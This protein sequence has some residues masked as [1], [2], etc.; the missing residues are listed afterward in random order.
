MKERIVAVSVDK[1][2]TFLT[3]VIHSHVQE[4]QKEE[5]TLRRIM[6]SSYQISNGFYRSIQDAFPEAKDDL[7]M[8]CSGVYIFSCSLSE[9]ELDKR[10]N[11]LFSAYY[12]ESRGQKLIRWVYFSSYGLDNIQAI[13]EAK[14]RLKEPKHWNKIVENNQE[15]LF[16]F[17]QV[18]EVIDNNRNNSRY[19]EEYPLFAKDIN[20]LCKNEDDK[21]RF[22]IAVLKADLDGMGAMFKQIHEYKDYKNISGILNEEISL[23][24]LHRAANCVFPQGSS[25]R[26]FPFYIAGDDI[27]FAVAIED[28]ARGVH[29]CGEIMNTV[30]KKIKES[31]SEEKLAI[32]MGVE[33]TYNKEPIR[34]YMDMVEAQLKNAKSSRTPN[35]L[36]DFSAM[37]ISIGNLTFFAIDY[38][39]IKEKKKDLTCKKRKCKCQKCRERAE[40]NRQLQNVPIWEYFLSDVKLLGYIRCRE[41]GCSGLLGNA[42]FFYTLLEDIT[43]ETTRD[44]PV[45]YINHVLYHLLPKYFEDSNQKLRKL[46]LLLNSRIIRQLYQKK[47]GNSEKIV[48]DKDTKLQ[49]ETY[50]RL[51]LFFCDARFRVSDQD[52][53]ETYERKYDKKEIYRNLFSRP[54]EYLFDICLSRTN[55]ELTNIF[56]NK[57]KDD[58]KHKK[59]YQRLTLEKSMFF[60]MR[61]IE[62]IPVDKAAE[63]IEF[64]NPSTIEA[65]QEITESNQRRREKGKLPNR[66]Y[67]DKKRFCE[68][69]EKTKVWDSDFID[70]LMLFY[71]Y[72][73]LVMKFKKMD[74]E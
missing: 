13:Q 61:D 38:K 42:S 51:M 49:F 33:I 19:E 10:L 62:S 20:A 31:G 6:N 37:K 7:L 34:Y 46:E 29:V 69:A 18:Q 23:D 55:A 9:A 15:L 17:C 21:K 45:K 40:L 28:L 1:I 68:I 30:K 64:R 44:N 47:E 71:Q 74:F 24:G 52:E 65:L 73:E 60:R 54:R 41:S 11:A 12:R 2:Q 4:S 25:G 8:E 56:V 35:V 59:G 3:E 70:S 43:E 14:K 50:L 58:K 67:F 32:S 22:R 26:L 53:W 5:A 48:L 63:M 27:F 36:R 57:V 16:S 39:K 72:N 66:L